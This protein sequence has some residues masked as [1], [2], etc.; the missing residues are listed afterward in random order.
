MH[1]KGDNMATGKPQQQ[2]KF[3]TIIHIILIVFI[4]VFFI[5]RFTKLGL[6]FSILLLLLPTLL[7]IVF[8]YMLLADYK[9]EITNDYLIVSWGLI[10]TDIISFDRIVSCERCFSREP[11]GPL[12]DF[13]DNCNILL[14]RAFLK[15]E[16]TNGQAVFIG[17][18]D[19]IESLNSLS[20]A[21]DLYRKTHDG[22]QPTK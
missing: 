18:N 6:L 8:I 21:L 1:P 16:L 11:R 13:T 7:L 2:P 5:L 17:T 10:R 20:K 14:N 19:P 12:Y 3:R 4:F 9:L 15:L 22:M